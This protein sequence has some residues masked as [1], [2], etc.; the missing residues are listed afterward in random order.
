MVWLVV[1]HVAEA[2]GTLMRWPVP[3]G[4]CSHCDCYKLTGLWFRPLVWLSVRSGLYCYG[5]IGVWKLTIWNTS[6]FG[7]IS[8]L[9]RACCL[10]LD[11]GC[12]LGGTLELTRIAFWVLGRQS[13]ILGLPPG[14]GLGV[15]SWV[16]SGAPTEFWGCGTPSWKWLQGVHW[17]GQ[18]A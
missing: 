5:H 9:P 10:V 12:F 15:Q 13:T 8:G 18:A 11:A 14:T 4:R 17:P 6:L 1:T 2:A 3:Q 16:G 7:E